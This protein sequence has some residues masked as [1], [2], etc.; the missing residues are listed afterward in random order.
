VLVGLAVIMLV[1]LLAVFIGNYQPLQLLLFTLSSAFVAAVDETIMTLAGLWF[2]AGNTVMF[3]VFG[4]P[5]LFF[6]IYSLAH[7]AILLYHTSLEKFHRFTWKII[8]AGILIGSFIILLFGQQNYLKKVTETPNVVILLS[9]LGIF[10][11]IYILIT[12]FKFVAPI[13]V[14]TALFASIMELLGNLSGMWTYAANTVP[15]KFSL[16]Y[17]LSEFPLFVCILWVFRILAVLC[18]LKIISKDIPSF[19]KIKAPN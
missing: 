12:Q 10:G 7:V 6:F 13:V 11:I 17:L 19:L 3:A 18:L 16:T 5:L 2:Y 9:L 8:L 1:C 15:V 14:L 4:W